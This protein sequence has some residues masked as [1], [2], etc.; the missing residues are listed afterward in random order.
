MNENRRNTDKQSI[1]NV[2]AH[3]LL[4]ITSEVE[5]DNSSL[6]HSWSQVADKNEA[7]SKINKKKWEGKPN[8]EE[9]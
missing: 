3:T 2:V 1:L 9:I 7:L 6:P 4:Y 5:L 8:N